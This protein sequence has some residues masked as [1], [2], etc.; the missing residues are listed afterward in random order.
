MKHG[1]IDCDDVLLPL[2]SNIKQPAANA[3]ESGLV[4]TICLLFKA[5]RSLFYVHRVGGV[6]NEPAPS[7]HR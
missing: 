2:K 5:T 1:A 3:H 7:N 4:R 6:E